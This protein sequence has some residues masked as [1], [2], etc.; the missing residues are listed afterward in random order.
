MFHGYY[1]ERARGNFIRAALQE[2]RA[3]TWKVVPRHNVLSK[4]P[5]D[6]DVLTVG[7]SHI[8]GLE[9]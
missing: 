9:P 5:S 6:F 1:T 7:F 3:G 4:L 2:S 8:S